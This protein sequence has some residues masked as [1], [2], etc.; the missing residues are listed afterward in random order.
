MIMLSMRRYGSCFLLFCHCFYVALAAETEYFTAAVYEHA[1]PSAQFMNLSQATA[2]DII[3]ENLAHY[4]RAIQIAKSKAADILV[5]P[6]Y[7]IFPAH[8]RNEMKPYLER[9]PDPKK[10]RV[11]PCN[12]GDKY[13][14]RR[15][16]FSLSCMAKQYKIVVVANMGGIEF[17]EGQKDCPED[18]A[19]QFNT[20][21]VFDN[22]GTLLLRYYKERLFYELGMDLPPEQE[23]PS[24]KTDFGT[25]ATFISFDIMFEK[26]S[27]FAQRKQVDAVALSSM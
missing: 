9:I 6:E 2:D 24:F 19:Y 20:N 15:I 11:N 26:M 27:A 12:E 10:I 5:F 4:N 25:F 23:D 13:Q 7:G 16:L 21:V 18:G 14:N 17:C 22:D 3:F 8:N 1:R